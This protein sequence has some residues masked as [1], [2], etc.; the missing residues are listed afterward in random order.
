MKPSSHNP[1][2]DQTTKSETTYH[3]S[4]LVNE[5]LTY[6]NPQPDKLYL[7][8]TFGG[9]GHT[10]AI[11]E[12][13]PRCKV[14]ALD[15]DQEA[16]KRNAEPLIEEFG[17]RLTVL[18]GN[19]IHLDRILKKANI[20]TLDGALADFG[21]S[22]FQIHEKEGFSFLTDTPLD[23]RM[24]PAHQYV[25]AADLLNNLSEKELADIFYIYGEE[26][27]SRSL[28][29]AIVQARTKKRFSTTGQLV[30]LVESIVHYKRGKGT[31]PATRAFQAL[32]IKV[33]HELDNIERFLKLSLPLIV[34]PGRLVCISFHSLEDRIV[35]YFF[36]E[37][38]D[39]ATILTPKPITASPEELSVN[40]SARSAKLRAIQKEK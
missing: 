15:W 1:L 5:V 31:H 10:R 39:F 20:T 17:D 38:R 8:A 18:W 35:K 21:T 2:N 40:P 30:Q 28:A 12:K 19:F 6:L 14:V 24:S 25:T 26:P 3:K 4:V 36:K 13:E 23:M 32:R 7:D 33:N 34:P 29:R 9:G 37:Q 27:R 16:I 11:L 22:Q